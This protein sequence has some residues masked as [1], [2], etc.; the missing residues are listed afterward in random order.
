MSDQPPYPPPYQPPAYNA[1]YGAPAYNS[2]YPAGQYGSQVPQGRNGMALAALIVGIIALL[3]CWSVV[4]GIIGGVV[5]AILGFVALSRARNK[6]ATDEAW[7]SA[8]W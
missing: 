2:P 3:T 6:Q 5:A 7:R 1:P 8:V 4:G